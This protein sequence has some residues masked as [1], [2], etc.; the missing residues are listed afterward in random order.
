MRAW[1]QS[2]CGAA[3]GFDGAVPSDHRWRIHSISTRRNDRKL[4]VP[5]SNSPFS[6][7]R[8]VT[9]SEELEVALQSALLD[10]YTQLKYQA[11]RELL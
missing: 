11:K 6:N 9:G 10:H 1:V 2:E 4:A 3:N 8:L 7:L 5:E